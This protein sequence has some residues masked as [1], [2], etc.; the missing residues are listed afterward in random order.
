MPLPLIVKAVIGKKI[1]DRKKKRDEFKE[2]FSS[3]EAFIEGVGRKPPVSG[4]GPSI[5][6]ASQLGGS[7]TLGGS[8]TST[9]RRKRR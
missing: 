2:R 9:I 4:T 8:V 3:P 5:D 1:A 6:V 7:S